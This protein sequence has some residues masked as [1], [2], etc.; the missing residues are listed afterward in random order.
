MVDFTWIVYTDGSQLV[1]SKSNRRIGDTEYNEIFSRLLSF[2]TVQIGDSLV[3]PT[4]AK[5]LISRIVAY[6]KQERI[7]WS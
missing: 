5:V 3:P 1:L 4:G 7:K 2:G 6:F